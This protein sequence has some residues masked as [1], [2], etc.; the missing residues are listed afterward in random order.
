MTLTSLFFAIYPGR[1]SWVRNC[2]PLI[3]RNFYNYVWYHGNESDDPEKWSLIRQEP[4]YSSYSIMSLSC[5]RTVLAL[6]N[7]RGNLKL[8]SLTGW[9]TL[10]LVAG[11]LFFALLFF[12]YRMPSNFQSEQGLDRPIFLYYYKSSPRNFDWLYYN[13]NF[14][15]C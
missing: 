4:E 15:I 10:F 13:L 2:N 7:I 14:V 8:V 9:R 6:G 11:F 5:C 1:S 3:F 12:R